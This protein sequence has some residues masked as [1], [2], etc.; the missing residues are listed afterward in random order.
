[1]SQTTSRRFPLGW[2]VLV[3]LLLAAVAFL[4]MRMMNEANA[5]TDVQTADVDLITVTTTVDSSGQ[6]APRQSAILYWKTTGTVA[7]VGA[8]VGDN[9]AAG[10]L[11]MALDPATTPPNIIG[12]QAELI[13]AQ[14]AL[15]NLL[16]PT[17]MTVA[18]AESAV[19]DAY[20]AQTQAEENLQRMIDLTSG[21]D[22]ALDQAVTDAR[23]RLIDTREVYPL[24]NAS[25]QAQ[26]LYRA[27]R[28]ADNANAVYQ[29]LQEQY[30]A[31]GDEEHP[32]L[33]PALNAAEAAYDAAEDLEA[34]LAA[35]IDT[36][37]LDL[38]NDESQAQADYDAA[39]NDFID[40]IT[41]DNAQVKAVNLVK[42][43]SQLTLAEAALFDALQRLNTLRS[44]PDPEEL[45]A[46]E[47]RLHAAQAS[48]DLVVLTAPFSGE[49]LA[50]H[51]ETGDLASQQQPA[52]TLA[53]MSELHITVLVDETEVTQ[54]EIGDPVTATFSALPDVEVEGEV[55]AIS[56]MGTTVQGLVKYEVEVV[57][58]QSNEDIPLGVTADVAIEVN[59][60][61]DVMAVPIDALQ[62][63]DQ[64]EYVNLVQADGSLTRVNVE[65]GAIVGDNVAVEG[66]LEAGDTVQVVTPEAGNGF[67]SGN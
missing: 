5:N 15:N 42:A 35:E 37:D 63:D 31:A 22:Q 64:G 26:M 14:E 2:V 55:S 9:V 57:L 6:V 44:A 20:L 21:V 17:T 41:G 8:A 24:A 54:I 12:A 43:Q 65:S 3:V 28:V 66:N 52:L 60:E 39:V 25:M 27:M 61:N 51:Y 40:A 46:A 59:V 67:R 33:L 19:A 48:V 49:V 1:M 30:D 18:S 36:D 58:E 34:E 4:A 16:N 56:T 38:L 7:E 10:D 53:D 62:N 32:E 13:A 50:V 23:N 11:L 47:A 45:A 29:D